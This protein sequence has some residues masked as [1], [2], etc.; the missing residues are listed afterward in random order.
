MGQT[1]DCG[2]LRSTREILILGLVNAPFSMLLYGF[3]L[4]WTFLV[5]S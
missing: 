5:A 3:F 2:C 1:E 4:F